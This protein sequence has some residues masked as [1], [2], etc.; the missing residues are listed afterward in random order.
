MNPYAERASSNEDGAFLMVYS[1]E[2]SSSPW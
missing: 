2:S 1:L